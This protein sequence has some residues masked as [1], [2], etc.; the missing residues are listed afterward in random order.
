MTF[1]KLPRR[2]NWVEMQENV[3][4]I[5]HIDTHSNMPNMF[6]PWCIFK[7]LTY[8]TVDCRLL[9]QYKNTE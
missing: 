1:L 2:Q 5:Q 4:E 9:V 3:E 6:I 7:S 8:C